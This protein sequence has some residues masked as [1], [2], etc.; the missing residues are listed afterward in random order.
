MFKLFGRFSKG[1]ALIALFFVLTGLAQGD[2]SLRSKK[3]VCV[4]KTFKASPEFKKRLLGRNAGW[5]YNWT[6]SSG[7]SV[8][9]KT[10][11]VPMVWGKQN[12][13]MKHLKAHRVPK[14]DKKKHPLLGFNEPDGKKQA[15]MTVAEAL[16]LWPQLEATNRRLGSPASIHADNDWMKNFMAQAKKKGLRVDFVCVHWYGPNNPDQLIKKLKKVHELYGK[17]I[18]ITEFA[19]ADWQ[20]KS[21]GKNRNKPEDVLK[22][23]KNVLPRLEKLDFVERYAWFSSWPGDAQLGPSALFNKAGKLTPLGKFYASFQQ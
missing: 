10:P 5:Y 17:P 9:E 23:M 6:G 19:V 20:A 8:V 4:G 12:W 21:L 14:V 1:A 3:G 22:F 13:A 15:N 18:W 2:V 7:N 16:K 11:F